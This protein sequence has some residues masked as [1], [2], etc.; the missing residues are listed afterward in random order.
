MMWM[1]RSWWVLISWG[2]M[3]REMGWIIE[4]IGVVVLKH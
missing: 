2:G 3:A 1:G 4:L